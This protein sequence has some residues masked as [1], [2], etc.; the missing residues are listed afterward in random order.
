MATKSQCIAS[1]ALSVRRVHILLTTSL[2]VLLL[3]L[4]P[5]AAI[6]HINCHEP[7]EQCHRIYLYVIAG[8]PPTNDT[9]DSQR[10]KSNSSMKWIILKLFGTIQGTCRFLVTKRFGEL[11]HNLLTK[12]QALA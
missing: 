7:V 6:Q 5:P 1:G 9:I 2:I 10:C 12:V 8:K 11:A 3:T 4:P